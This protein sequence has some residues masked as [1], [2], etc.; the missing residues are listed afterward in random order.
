[1]T[2]L[3]KEIMQM[4]GFATVDVDTKRYPGNRCWRK[5]QKILSKWRT[6]EFISLDDSN[7]WTLCDGNN[8][9]E[10]KTV[11]QFNIAMQFIGEKIRIEDNGYFNILSGDIDV[12]CVCD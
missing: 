12:N 11:E 3:T 6:I 2:R 5:W 10:C 7:I 8:R 4:A 9:L 1:M